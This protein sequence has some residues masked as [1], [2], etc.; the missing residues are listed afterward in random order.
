MFVN[1]MK[2]SGIFESDLD[3]VDTD[4]LNLMKKLYL[5]QFTGDP[6]KRHQAMWLWQGFEFKPMTQSMQEAEFIDSSKM[7]R[8]RVLS[9]ARVHGALLNTVDVNRATA[10]VAEEITRMFAVQPVLDMVADKITQ[11]ILP[12]YKGGEEFAVQ[13]LGVT[14]QD[15]LRVAPAS[16]Q[17]QARGALGAARPAG[18]A[19]PR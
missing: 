13:F 12:L 6:K 4:Q 2:L 9:V 1:G 11:C 5:E 8:E 14:P 3:T 15:A 16:R 18:R 17:Y 10:M 7:W 19:R